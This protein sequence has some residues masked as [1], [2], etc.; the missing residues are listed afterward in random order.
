MR[1]DEMTLEEQLVA[2]RAIAEYRRGQAMAEK[3]NFETNVPVTIALK[4]ADGKRV[5]SRY[6]DYEVY[7]STT[8]G[9]SFYASPALAEKI[10]ALELK[11]GEPFSICRREAKTPG[12]AR[13][14]VEWQVTRVE[15]PE[16]TVSSPSAPVAATRSATK[17]MSVPDGSNR[18]QHIAP[19]PEELPSMAQILSGALISSI[20][21]MIMA[22]DYAT[23]KGIEVELHLDFN[24]ED[25]R[26]L[27]STAVI[28][29]FKDAEVRMRYGYGIAAEPKTAQRV[30]GGVQ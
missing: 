5:D 25:A 20:N 14:G 10:S 21:A 7:Y 30:N 6:N 16:R 2:S 28:Q 15:Q 17:A 11:A 24:G 4:F 9:R 22:R 23:S 8:D 27:A 29:Y 19:A 3:I 26:K 13:K 12:S 18:T 1:P